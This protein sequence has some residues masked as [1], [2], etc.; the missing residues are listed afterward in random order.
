[1]V[2]SITLIA[3]VAA[4]IG[5]VPAGPDWATLRQVVDMKR[6]QC[7]ADHPQSHLAIEH[8]TSKYAHEVYAAAGVRDMD[9]LDAY[10]AQREVIAERLDHGQ[11]SETEANAE[12]A[13]T[14]ALINSEMQ[15]RA[16]SRAAT[17]AAIL[18][19]MPVTCTTFGATTTCN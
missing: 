16:A 19:T 10:G 3:V 8:C 18:S 17:T 4:V 5:C 1:M 12:I 9:L 13:T 7:A 2:R 6:A 15:Q 11:I 14:R